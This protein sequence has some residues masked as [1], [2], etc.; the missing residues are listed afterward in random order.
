M[1]P[2]TGALKARRQGKAKQPSVFVGGRHAGGSRQSPITRNK[3]PAQQAVP[4]KLLRWGRKSCSWMQGR[5][6]L[7][8]WR[9]LQNE[10]E[11]KAQASV[12]CRFWGGGGT[13][14]PLLSLYW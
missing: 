1:A 3:G 6:T 9:V 13:I 14:A 5:R 12:F 8:Q 2:K 7:Q 10:D 4:N 11:V